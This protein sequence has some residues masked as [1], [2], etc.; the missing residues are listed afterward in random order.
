MSRVRLEATLSLQE[1]LHLLPYPR[2]GRR[3]GF[4]TSLKSNVTP[5]CI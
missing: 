2:E 4:V 1:A 3:K 5:T